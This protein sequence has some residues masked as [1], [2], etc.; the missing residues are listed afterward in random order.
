LVQGG[1]L[2]RLPM[3][4]IE[5]PVAAVGAAILALSL[6]LLPHADTTRAFL[7]V[8]ALI[9]LGNGLLVPTL[10][11]MASRHVHGRA[12]GRVLGLNSSAGALGRFLGPWLAAIP[13]PAAF[14]EW[15]RPLAPAALSAAN[16]A[17]ATA[18]SVSAGLMIVACLLILAIK[19]LEIQTPGED[20][21]VA[22][23]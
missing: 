7:G 17:Y 2:R 13:L 6:Y 11:G 15:P 19:P 8:S 21:G 23:A 22:T 5:K 10:S 14:S 4:R 12:Q 16:H 18:F 20:P 9:A 1:L 3:E